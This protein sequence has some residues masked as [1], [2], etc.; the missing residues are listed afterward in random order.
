MN[1]EN[2][3]TIFIGIVLALYAAIIIFFVIKGARK[4]KNIK[5]FAV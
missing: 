5:D 2:Y 3:G 1:S 4:A